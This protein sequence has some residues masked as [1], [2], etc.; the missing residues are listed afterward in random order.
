M[1]TFVDMVESQVSMQD[2][3][4]RSTATKGVRELAPG[5]VG[6]LA[7][8]SMERWL[9]VVVGRVWATRTL[10]RGQAEDRWI[11]AGEDLWLP[12][13][14]AWVVEGGPHA[15]VSLL[16]A[17]PVPQSAPVRGMAWLVRSWSRSIS[18]L[19]TLGRPQVRGARMTG[20]DSSGVP[21]IA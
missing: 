21:S 19:G 12:A 16:E 1:E 10:R 13:G 7:P 17:W 20:A 14:S 6:T 3:H 18:R 5:A 15:S 4:R 2:V 9:H 8:A 11:E